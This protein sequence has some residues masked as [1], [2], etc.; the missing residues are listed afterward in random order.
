MALHGYDRVVLLTGFPDFGARQLAKQLLA[1]EPRLLLY[2]VV[3]DS[4]SGAAHS[5]V[6]ALPQAQRERVVMFSGDPSAMDMGLSGAEL[7]ELAAQV[8]TIFHFA[9]E[10]WSSDLASTEWINVQGT[11]EA[12]EMAKA[13]RLLGNLVLLSSVAVAGTRDGVAYENDLDTSQTSHSVVLQTTVETE[14]IA[15]RAM[16]QVPITVL[17]T[18]VVIGDTDTGEVDRLEGPYD[19]MVTII[20]AGPHVSIALPLRGDELLNLVPVDY[21][22]RAAHRIGFDTRAPGR[23]VHVVDSAP[24]PARRVFELVA[25]ATGRRSP[26]ASFAASMA[27]AISRGPGLKPFIKGSQTLQE[28]VTTNV[29]YDTRNADELLRGTGIICP[30]FESYVDVI[31]AYVQKCLREQKR[32]DTTPAQEADDPFS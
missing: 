14:K 28:M 3:R 10:S 11:R 23:T 24:L 16:S 31:G 15:R 8:H 7:R 9:H 22:A 2:C 5:V 21:V 30:P 13:C 19:V 29:R 18:S 32:K 17:R 1:N 4:C 25:H 6:Q 26:H 20:E 12:I 27:R